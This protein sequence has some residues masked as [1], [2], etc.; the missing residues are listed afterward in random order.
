MSNI[1]VQI[2]NCIHFL[3]VNN[4]FDEISSNCD[5]E[6]GIVASNQSLSDANNFLQSST[7]SLLSQ[8]ISNDK[9]SCTNNSSKRK[10]CFYASNCY[11]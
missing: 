5:S 10:K 6:N 1:I 3:T 8:S 9:I 2:I 4:G 7:N 11:R